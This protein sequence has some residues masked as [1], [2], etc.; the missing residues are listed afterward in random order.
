MVY[1]YTFK[2][3]IGIGLVHL[4]KF[5]IYSDLKPDDNGFSY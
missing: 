3:A 5:Y 2:N 1:L 4:V